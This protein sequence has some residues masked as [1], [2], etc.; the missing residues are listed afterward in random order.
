MRVK[1]KGINNDKTAII[2]ITWLTLIKGFFIRGS[3]HNP[4]INFPVFDFVGNW[5]LELQ[6]GQ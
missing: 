5:Y 2:A 6:Y 4:H 1:S 3:P